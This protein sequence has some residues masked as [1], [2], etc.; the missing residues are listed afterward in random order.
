MPNEPHAC[1]LGATGQIGRAAVAALARDGWRVTAASRRGGRDARWP[2]GVRA[3]AVDRD[4][5]GALAA[6][7]G[8][9]CDLLVDTCAVQ[10][11]HG[12]T[13][14]S[15]ADRIGSA[16]VISSGAVYEDER[17]RSFATQDEPD[18]FPAYPVPITESQRR[19]RPGDGD[20][21]SRKALLEDELLAAGDRLPVT[22]LRA[23]AVHGPH[24]RTPR[25][26]YFAK[27]WLDGRRTRILAYGGAS[28]F[29]PVHVD[30]LAE[31]VRLAARRPGSRA[32][33]A[34]DPEAPTV[35]G[36]AR[37]VDGVLGWEC[38]TVLWEG[39]PPEDVPL[40][41]RTPWSLPHPLVLDMGAA[42]RE[43][44]YRPVTG[45]AESLP[46]TLEWLLDRLRAEGD[47]RTAFPDMAAAYDRWGD[48]FDYEAEDRLLARRADEGSRGGAW[49]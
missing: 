4:E 17:G 24:C 5:E 20:Y 28:R 10:I 26:L 37:A 44:G 42:A 30:N 34:A 43:L 8:D 16:V 25:E 11:R 32:L 21:G 46:R 31:L 19:V 40:V 18:G 2:E 22:L 39:A 23:G 27:R 1:V 45:Y 7:L 49:R 29:H 36:I 13:V 33:N 15:L 47:W 41:G 38:E 35:A 14:L 9:G 48:L 12:R 3:V 6:A